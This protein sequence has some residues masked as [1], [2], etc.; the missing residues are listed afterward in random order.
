MNG[1]IFMEKNLIK[2]NDVL[3]SENEKNYRVNVNWLNCLLPVAM[4]NIEENGKRKIVADQFRKAFN[5]AENDRTAYVS[6]TVEEIRRCAG[7][8]ETAPQNV[9]LEIK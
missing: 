9:F 3:K 2:L 5:K 8:V 4:R 6:M 7:G 1:R